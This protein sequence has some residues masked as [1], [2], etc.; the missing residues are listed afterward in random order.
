M[1]DAEFDGFEEGACFGARRN[2]SPSFVFGDE[3]LG[4]SYP[5]CGATPTVTCLLWKLC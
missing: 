2:V 1:H 3:R 5:Y 4:W